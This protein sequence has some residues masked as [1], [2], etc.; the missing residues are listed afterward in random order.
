M[1]RRGLRLNSTL[2]SLQLTLG[3]LLLE[4]A[5]RSSNAK[6]RKRLAGEAKT[7]LTKALT[8]NKLLARDHH[9][10]LQQAADLLQ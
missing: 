6:D 4:E 7:A 9:Q 1:A 8:L 3:K 2:P 10:A 5:V